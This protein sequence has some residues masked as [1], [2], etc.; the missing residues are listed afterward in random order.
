[1]ENLRRR[2]GS[3][4]Y[5]A[6]S[7]VMRDVLVKV[8]N[9]SYESQLRE[10]RSRVLFLWGE[11]DGEVPVSVARGAVDILAEAGGESDLRV[12]DGVGHHLPIEAPEELRKAIEAVLL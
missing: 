4:D 5:R 6:A 9:E 2:S 7:G 12:L 1:M 8:V 10:V 11:N 3:V